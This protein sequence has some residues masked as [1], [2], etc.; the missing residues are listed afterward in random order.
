[1]TQRDTNLLGEADMNPRIDRRLALLGLLS[2]AALGRPALAQTAAPASVTVAG[3]E[4]TSTASVG[5]QTLVLNGAGVSNILSTRATAVGLYLGSKTTGVA[6]ALAMPGAKRV[7]MVALRDLS[8]RDLS[9]ALLDRLRQNAAPGEVEANVL[10]IAGMGGVFG[11]R[12]RLPKGDVLTLDYLPATKS[13]EARV[14]GERVSEPIVGERFYPLLMKVWI[15]P[16]IR[17]GTRDALMG[18]VND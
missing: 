14:N 2:A 7:R 11:T 8:G 18:V 17:A 9:N 4:F 5:G 1:M 15:G 10:Q 3:M 13:T 6:A 12:T 16:R